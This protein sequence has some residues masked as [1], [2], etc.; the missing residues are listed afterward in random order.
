MY[1]DGCASHLGCTVTLR[2]GG[3]NELKKVKQIIHFMT[4]VAYHAKLETSFLMD[5]FAMPPPLPEE[6]VLNISALADVPSTSAGNIGENGTKNTHRLEEKSQGIQNGGTTHEEEDSV[7]IDEDCGKMDENLNQSKPVNKSDE[8]EKVNLESMA[9][10]NEE[11]VTKIL[12]RQASQAVLDFSDPLQSYQKCHDESIFETKTHDKLTEETRRGS[13]VFKKAM[14]DVILSSSP[15]MKADIPYLESDHGQSC[16]LRKYFQKEIYC[17]SY[18]TDQGIARNKF[19][20]EEERKKTKQKI[21]CK[22]LPPHTFL[23]EKIT[24][25]VTGSNIQVG[26]S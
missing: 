13:H 26:I 18:F 3:V 20:D 23:L 17:S 6:N 14:S 24:S 7:K 25:P 22:L 5:E 16:K 4:Y 11:G 1:F 2:G 19:T 10:K 9:D 21:D 15:Y 8:K 12:K